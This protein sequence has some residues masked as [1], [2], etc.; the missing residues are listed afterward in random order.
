M[1]TN[2]A[3][4]DYYALLQVSPTC[5]TRILEIAYHYFAK[6]YHPD[7]DETADLERFNKVREAYATLKD[8]EK[9][10]A[11]DR[12][13]V[14]GAQANGFTLDAGLDPDD[15]GALSDAQIHQK[16]LSHLYKRRREYSKEPGAA[17]WLLQELLDCTDDEFAFHAWYLKSKGWIVATEQGTLAITVEGV[18]H[19]IQQSRDNLTEKIVIAQLERPRD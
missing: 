18:D 13:R 7:H 8:P 2:G 15:Q 1:S 11:Y 19:V 17:A 3:P 6:R 12:T 16:I 9:R 14:H 4:E 10:A 5:D